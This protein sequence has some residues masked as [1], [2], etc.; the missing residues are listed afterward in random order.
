[1]TQ[2]VPGGSVSF[3]TE[4]A[5]GITSVWWLGQTP[6]WMKSRPAFYAQLYLHSP[7][8]MNAGEARRASIRTYWKIVKEYA[9]CPSKLGPFTIFS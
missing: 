6:D 4:A 2:L 8:G 7:T 9:L 1:M 5:G 3:E